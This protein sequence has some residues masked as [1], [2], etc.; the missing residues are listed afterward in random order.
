MNI[1]TLLAVG[2]L[3]MAVQPALGQTQQQAGQ[4]K[5]QPRLSRAD[6]PLKPRILQIGLRVSDIEKAHEFYTKVLGLERGTQ[7]ELAPGV[8]EWF[9]NF[10]GQDRSGTT[11]SLV[12][13]PGAK[14]DAVKGDVDSPV[15]LNLTVQD[16]KSIV[17]KVV[18][19]GGRI[20]R[21]TVTRKAGG[22]FTE[23]MAFITDPDGHLIE[24]TYFY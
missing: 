19:G 8:H 17:A 24:I 4:Q 2:V 16:V 13:S 7:L 20:I 10:P 5:P 9:Y 3:T 21:P 22:M 18:A 12:N 11:I 6:L 14:P 1:K 15:T 23:D